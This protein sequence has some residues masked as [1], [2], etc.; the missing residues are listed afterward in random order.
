MFRKGLREVGDVVADRD[1][2]EAKK[3]GENLRKSP[4]IYRRYK[5]RS[6]TAVIDL[7]VIDLNIH[8]FDHVFISSCFWDLFIPY[9]LY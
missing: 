4:T 2:E 5:L 1:D 7:I 3:N 6:I 8:G 9:L